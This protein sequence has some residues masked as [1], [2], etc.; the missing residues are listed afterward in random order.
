MTLALEKVSALP[1]AGALSPAD[2]V[3]V[4]QLVG[5]APGVLTSM[6]TTTGAIVAAAVAA[7]QAAI[8]LPDPTK[9]ALH[10]ITGAYSFV[11]T[12]AGKL[13]RHTDATAITATVELNATQPFA[14]TQVVTGRQA[15]TGQI[16]ISPVSGAVIINVPSGYLSKTRAQGSDYMLHYVAADVWDLTGDLAPTP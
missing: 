16:S 5:T 10:S 13:V 11:P 3:Y 14:L 7:A 6:Q 4:V 12:D 15:G 8:V 9:V 1:N 2:I